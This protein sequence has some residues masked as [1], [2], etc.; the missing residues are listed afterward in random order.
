MCIVAQSIVADGGAPAAIQDIASL[1]GAHQERDLYVYTKKFRIPIEPYDIFV[2]GQKVSVILVHQWL[3]CISQAGRFTPALLGSSDEADILEFWGHASAKTPWKDAYK[4]VDWSKLLPLVWHYDGAE[5]HRNSEWD[6]FSYRCALSHGQDIMDAKHLYTAVPCS[7]FK[8]EK[9]HQLHTAITALIKWDMEVC[10]SGLWPSKDYLGADMVG[11]HASR[12]GLE[13]ANGWKATLLGC[14]ADNKARVEA[15]Q[16]QRNYMATLVCDRCLACQPGCKKSLDLCSFYNFDANAG[17]KCTYFSHEGYM[18]T[19]GTPSPWAQVPGWTLHCAFFDLMHTVFLGTARLLLASAVHTLFKNGLLNGATAEIG[20]A[21]LFSEFKQWGKTLG[22]YI[23]A[24]TFT[25]KSL[26]FEDLEY[27]CLS[28][29]IKA[30]TVKHLLSFM[31]HKMKNVQHLDVLGTCLWSLGS[32][33]DIWYAGG[34]ILSK[35]DAAKAYELGIVHLQTYQRLAGEAQAQGLLLYKIIPKFHYF[36]HILEDQLHTQLNPCH[37]SN[38]FDC[39]SY[40]GKVKKPGKA[41]RGAKNMTKRA[42][43]RHLLRLAVRWNG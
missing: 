34:L 42:M 5:V 2:C 21:N 13:F 36:L 17:Y 30:I 28:T 14:N 38:A 25:A 41:C 11:E 9:K 3:H 7:L 1:H 8:G 24:A 26:G 37:V 40:L 39:E 32:C 18:R 33:I 43:Q 22:I 10:M 20:C 15:N 4:D 23:P 31:V 29:T 12:A 19:C 35:S 27:A 16:F 6:I